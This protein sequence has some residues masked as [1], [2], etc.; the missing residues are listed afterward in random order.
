[1]T[2]TGNVI[3]SPASLFKNKNKLE[4]DPKIIKKRLDITDRIRHLWLNI[5][6]K[7]HCFSTTENFIG[8]NIN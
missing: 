8:K 5:N 1:M 4:V 3:V 2:T 6:W 7:C